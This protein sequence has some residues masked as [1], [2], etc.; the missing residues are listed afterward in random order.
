MMVEK[1]GLVKFLLMMARIDLGGGAD[2]VVC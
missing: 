2:L 1:I